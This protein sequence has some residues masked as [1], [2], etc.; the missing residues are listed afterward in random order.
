MTT[1]KLDN[2]G[3]KGVSYK[4]AGSIKKLTTK[5]GEEVSLNTDP[6]KVKA[7]KL[8]EVAAIIGYPV[9]K[10]EDAF[11]ELQDSMQVERPESTVL[12][13]KNADKIVTSWSDAIKVDANGNPNGLNAEAIAILLAPGHARIG[14]SVFRVENSIGEMLSEEMLKIDII[15]GLKSVGAGDMYAM[16][17]YKLVRDQMLPLVPES[18]LGTRAGFLPVRNGVL[19]ITKNKL[20]KADGIY[21]KS[22]SIDF[23][24]NATE[25]PK[26]DTMIRNMFT[27]EQRDMVLSIFGAALS[28]RRSPFI[29]ALS[30]SGR[31]G[32][33]LL[34]EILEAMMMELI[35][36]ERLENL[37]KDF[38]NAVF[39]GKVLSWQTEVSSARKFTEEIKNVTGGTTITIRKKFIN[40]ELQY[41]LQMTCI[42]DTNSVPHFEQSPAIEERMR[43]VNMPHT[44]V[45][46]LTGDP[47]EVLIEPELVNGWENELPAFLNKL[48]VY[49]K[50]FLDNGHLMYDIKGTGE[51]LRK[52]SNILSDFI[53]NYCDTEDDG[54]RATMLT[55]YNHFKTYA[56]KMNT[57]VPEIEQVRYKLRNEYSLKIRANRI[58]GLSLRKQMLLD[59]AE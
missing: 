3:L 31:N 1:I 51:E 44:F 27:D 2:F 52:R 13:G 9:S 49:S 8:N 24:P 12:Q 38:V 54:A 36:T 45:Y 4:F 10:V 32:K 15:K 7:G 37:E 23:D 25:C 28:G 41:P 43:F 56:A 33:S 57:A 42:L 20:V 19:D 18:K 50:H 58:E 14:D 30:G 5:A 21:L 34:R 53:D 59:L 35:T 17:T 48:L 47:R 55:F 40:G 39:M 29:L 16:N 6:W 22:L 11:I 26:I 46:E